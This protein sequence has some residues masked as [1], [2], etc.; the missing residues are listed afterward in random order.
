[1]P[2]RANW[3][4]SLSCESCYQWLRDSTDPHQLKERKTAEPVLNEVFR[5][6]VNLGSVR[7]D[8]FTRPFACSGSDFEAFFR[9]NIAE[10]VD[11][12]GVIGQSRMVV[13]RGLKYFLR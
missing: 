1:M 5:Q 12:L 8:Y 11:D 7:E 3:K 2:P 9:G 4:G 6:P 10:S 13:G